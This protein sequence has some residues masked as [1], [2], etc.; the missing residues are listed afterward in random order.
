MGNLMNN[1]EKQNKVLKSFLSEIKNLSD[2]QQEYNDLVKYIGVENIDMEF[3]IAGRT[4][5]YVWIDTKEHFDYINQKYMNNTIKS[6]EDLYNLKGPSGYAYIP[7][8][9]YIKSKVKIEDLN[10][11]PIEPTNKTLTVS[12]T[13]S[14]QDLNFHF[15]NTSKKYYLID[16]QVMYYSTFR[17]IFIWVDIEKVFNS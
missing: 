4:Q 10:I 7:G 9:E 6:K 12:A 13:G 17:N 16:Q 11:I 15:N 1:I 3:W 2:Q 8:Y 5:G 14:W